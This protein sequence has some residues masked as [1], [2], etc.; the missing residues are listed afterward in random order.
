MSSGSKANGI[1]RRS[2]NDSHHIFT[3]RRLLYPSQH[4]LQFP[5]NREQRLLD[6]SRQYAFVQIFLQTSD[7][8][9]VSTDTLLKDHVERADHGQDIP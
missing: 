2:L 1:C 7:I 8:E 3:E 9:S 4:E 5:K 6:V